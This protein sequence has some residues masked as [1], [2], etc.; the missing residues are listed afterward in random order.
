MNSL[1]SS[2]IVERIPHSLNRVTK[3]GRR[4]SSGNSF[5]PVETRTGPI[6]IP[7]RMSDGRSNGIEGWFTVGELERDESAGP[8]SIDG[9]LKSQ[10]RLL[11]GE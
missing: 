7:A 2:P 9:D 1:S 6:Q 5:V 3:R 10:A 4:G 11:T 8:L